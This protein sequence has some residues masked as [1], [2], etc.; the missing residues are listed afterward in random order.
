MP[1]CQTLDD[2]LKD[3]DPSSS[4]WSDL[5]TSLTQLEGSHI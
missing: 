3:A 4:T 5:L 1:S 2:T